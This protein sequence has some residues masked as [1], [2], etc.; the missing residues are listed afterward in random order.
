MLREECKRSGKKVVYVF[1]DIETAFD[2]ALK[3]VMEWA[4]RKKD[5]PKAIVRAVMSLYQSEKTK[6][7]LRFELSEEFQVQIVVHQKLYCRLWFS[8]LW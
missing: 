8:Q 4:V 3:K 7:R 5:L 2:R 1:V 6:V